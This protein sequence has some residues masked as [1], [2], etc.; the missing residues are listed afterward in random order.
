MDNYSPVRGK[1]VWWRE[2]PNSED[3]HNAN[4]KP[5]EKR[6]ECSCFVEG[7]RWTFVL[8]EIPLECPR[9]RECRYFVKGY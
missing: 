1:C 4:V 8:A 5:A 2:V 3:R 9:S 6:T 7:Y